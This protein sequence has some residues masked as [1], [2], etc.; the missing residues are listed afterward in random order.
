[1]AVIE[2]TACQEKNVEIL[3][4]GL[5]FRVYYSGVDRNFHN[6]IFYEFVLLPGC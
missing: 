4:I 1:M 6:H 5:K 2:V 3:V